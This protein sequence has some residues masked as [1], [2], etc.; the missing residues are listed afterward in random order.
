[1]PLK[2]CQITIKTIFILIEVKHK[3]NVVFKCG[4]ENNCRFFR[5]LSMSLNA[6][7]F[8]KA[9]FSKY[10]S[11]YLDSMAVNNKTFQSF[12]CR[13]K[14]IFC[15]PKMIWSTI[16]LRKRENHF[17]A[18]QQSGQFCE[19][20]P[21]HHCSKIRLDLWLDR[22]NWPLKP[23]VSAGLH[24]YRGV[25][26]HGDRGKEDKGTRVVGIGKGGVLTWRYG[27]WVESPMRERGLSSR[28]VG[29]AFHSGSTC[30]PR[31]RQQDSWRHLG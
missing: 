4:K 5:S 22:Q 21:Q 11:T 13:Q 19:K 14:N 20:S 29:D 2:R 28:E 9:D 31:V 30:S 7:K 15:A 6:S 26:E 1:M 16:S 24:S 23:H 10:E 18:I 27:G 17:I 25:R 12:N 3:Y 8:F